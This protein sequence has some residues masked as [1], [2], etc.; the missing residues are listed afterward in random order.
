[1]QPDCGF[2]PQNAHTLLMVFLRIWLG[3]FDFEGMRPESSSGSEAGQNSV[4]GA[5]GGT[6]Q[7][8]ARF[9]RGRRRKR[10]GGERR[11]F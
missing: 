4:A 11:D 8:A 3:K 1:R 10:Q 7:A 2:F 5:Q 9:Y 6:A